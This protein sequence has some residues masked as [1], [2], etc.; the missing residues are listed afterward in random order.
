MKSNTVVELKGVNGEW[1]TL[2]GPDAG[3]KGVYLGTGLKG[4]F[5]PPVKVVWEEPGNWPGARYLAHRVQKRDIVFGVEILHEPGDSWM[6]RDGEWRKAWSFEKDCTLYVTTEESGTRWLK[7]RLTE[8]PEVDMF[9]DPAMN[10]VNRVAMVCVAQD[11]FWYEDDKVFSAVTTKDTR[12]DP[13]ALR[14][15]WPWPQTSLPKET[16]VIDIKGSDGGVNPTDQIIWPKWTVPGSTEKP[17]EPYVPGLPWLGAPK[18]KATIWTLPDYSFTDDEHK[19]RSLRLPALIGGLRTR[20]VQAFNIDGKPTGGSFKLR[21]G[22]ETTS[23][24]PYNATP[25]QVQ[26]ALV[27]LASIANGDVEV[28]RDPATSEKQT[29]QVKGGATG[30]TFTLTFNGQTTGPI[31]VYAD[32]LAVYTE[33]TKLT[34]I[35]LLAVKVDMESEDCVQEI[36]LR[37]DPTAG[38]FTLTLDGETTAPI[39]YNATDFRVAAELVKLPSIGPLAVS[40][41]GSPWIRREAGGPWKIRFKSRLAGVQVNPLVGDASGLTGGAGI[42][43]H[44]QTITPGG[45]KYIVEFK[46]NLDGYNL[47]EMTGNPA[48]LT[49]GKNNTVEVD[50]IRDGQHPYVVTFTGLLEGKEQPTL[51]GDPAGLTGGTGSTI[52]V[53]HK[54]KGF[55]F[56]A[57][58]CVVDSDPRVEQVVSESKS[59]IW[60]RMNGVRF[61]HPIPPYTKEA[62]FVVEVS[63]C[64][65]GQMVTVR[66]PRPW[67]RPWGLQ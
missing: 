41:S 7:L 11:P 60:S 35:G 9:M 38:T 26:A 8:S 30:G 48:G 40:V 3:D 10:G 61:R 4:L 28:K 27:A 22:S 46:N 57:E 23:N 34:G 65:P 56:P 62:R 24:I 19:T 31:P 45:R 42:E 6:T 36:A 20:D 50:T 33:L 17:A 51:V 58:N 18:S 25:A 14:L 55:T 1:F 64:A 52:Q 29:V 59:P 63:G 12:F 47:P 2:A 43:V 49:G 67:S 32:P 37:G 15:P 54:V 39:P 21:F 13:N 16:L 66:L 44:Q 53:V 5:D